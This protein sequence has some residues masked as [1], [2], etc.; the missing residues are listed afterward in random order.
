MKLEVRGEARNTNADVLS[1][2]A[3][4]ASAPAH[5]LLDCLHSA[6]DAFSHGRISGMTETSDA[7]GG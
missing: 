2:G 7:K 6:R 4:S 5:L 1:S 3:R